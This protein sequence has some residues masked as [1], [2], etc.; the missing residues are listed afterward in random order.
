[1]IEKLKN[2]KTIFIIV[3]AVIIIISI[4]AIF[5]VKDD[6]RISK[7]KKILGNKY[8]DILSIVNL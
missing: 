1:M 8:Y 3:I 4:F 7:V 6:N 2:K 5:N